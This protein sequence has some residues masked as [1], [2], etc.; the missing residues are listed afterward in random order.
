MTFKFHTS[1]STPLG[2]PWALARRLNVTLWSHQGVIRLRD[3]NVR[4]EE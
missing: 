1:T 4:P 3:E 2:A